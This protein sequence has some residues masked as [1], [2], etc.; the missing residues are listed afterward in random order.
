MNNIGIEEISELEFSRIYPN[1][2]E[3]TFNVEL[4]MNGS[5]ELVVTLRNS[6]GQEIQ[7]IQET[8]E[9]NSIISFEINELPNGVYFVEINGEFESITKRLIK[10]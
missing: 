4:N 1:P 7:Q 9:G 5:E 10:H 6:L 3:G 2:T 8:L